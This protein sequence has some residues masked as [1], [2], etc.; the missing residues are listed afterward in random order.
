[1]SYRENVQKMCDEIDIKNPI[2]ESDLKVTGVSFKI[3]GR[4][5]C[6]G[7]TEMNRAGRLFFQYQYWRSTFGYMKNIPESLLEAGKEFFSENWDDAEEMGRPM[8]VAFKKAT[9]LQIHWK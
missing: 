8:L 5:K 1:M 3:D 9:Y 7:E 4:W 6:F 2:D